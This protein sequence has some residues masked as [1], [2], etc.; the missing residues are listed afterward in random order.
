[1]SIGATVLLENATR[2]LREDR[3]VIARTARG[4]GLGLWL[5][6][7]CEGPEPGGGSSTTGD[8]GTATL[9]TEPAANASCEVEG[10]RRCDPDG[11]SIYVCE[12][13]QWDSRTCRQECKAAD[14]PSCALGCIIT[15][16]GEDCLCV[17]S[18]SPCGV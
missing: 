16:E 15:A 8:S 6:L 5:C 13:A 9:A 4:W 11:S 3:L 2:G 18:S 12:S 7:G 1:M 17:P 10:E 14:V